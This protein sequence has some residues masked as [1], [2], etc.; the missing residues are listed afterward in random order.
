M[1]L[2]RTEVAEINHARR[3]TAKKLV[4]IPLC[5]IHNKGRIRRLRDTINAHLALTTE[6]IRVRRYESLLA[7]RMKEK[8]E[9]KHSAGPE[10][11]AELDTNSGLR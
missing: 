10:Q 7:L 9:Y 11:L 8:D 2:S 3:Q 5:F 4:H 1:L 6:I